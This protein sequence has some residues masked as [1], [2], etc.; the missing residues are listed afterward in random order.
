M[1]K[2]QVSKKLRTRLKIVGATLTAIFSLFSVFAATAAWFSSN[3]AVSVTGST[4]RVEV[5]E[6]LEYEMYYLSS[7]TDDESTT[8]P[9]N[10]KTTTGFYSG[11]QVAYENATFTKIN[12]EDGEVTDDPNPLN[13]SHLWPAHK[14]TFAFVITQSTM[15]RLSISDWGEGEGSEALDAAKTNASQYVRLSWAI[16]IYGAAYNVEETNDTAADVATGFASY[17]DDHNTSYTDVFDY[18][19]SSLANEPPVD[20]DPITVVDDVPTNDADERT[21]VFFTIAFSN[22]ESTF[23][24][25]NDSTGYYDHYVSGSLFGFNSNCYEGLSLTSLVFQIS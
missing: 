13:I 23:Y 6:Q 15:S 24:K 25:Y 9:G 22:D 20:K 17:Y 8:R 18:S 7:F 14:L 2:K 5:P 16:D 21:I 10:Y 11:Y 3:T 12:F 4:I 1:L 19:E